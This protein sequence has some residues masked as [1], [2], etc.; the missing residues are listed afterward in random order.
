VKQLLHFWQPPVDDYKRAVD[1]AVA[2]G[3]LDVAVVLVKHLHMQDRAAAAALLA[4]I[5]EGASAEEAVALQQSVLDGWLDSECEQQRAALEMEK[6]ELKVQR[7]GLQ[8]LLVGVACMQ[9]QADGQRQDR[10]AA[11][12]DE[13][14]ALVLPLVAEMAGV[15][16]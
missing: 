5:C 13:V 10:C 9:R 1:T 4:D 11:K 12:T 3:K 8:Q 16:V 14:A 6:Q 7:V 15:F 2:A